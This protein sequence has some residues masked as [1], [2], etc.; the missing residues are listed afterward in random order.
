MKL[1][2]GLGINNMAAADTSDSS[3]TMTN[4]CISIVTSLGL[5]WPIKRTE[6][7]TSFAYHQPTLHGM[8]SGVDNL[9]LTADNPRY[10][11]G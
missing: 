2:M 7:R 1:T 6:I 11:R 4:G 9:V 5:N 10:V 3:Y 8:D